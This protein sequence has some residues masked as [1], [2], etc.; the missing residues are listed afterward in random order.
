MV[1]P[2]GKGRIKEIM[3]AGSYSVIDPL[4]VVEYEDKEVEF[5]M[6]HVWPVRQARPVAES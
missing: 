3:E 5:T 2:K 1:P 4:V 6:S